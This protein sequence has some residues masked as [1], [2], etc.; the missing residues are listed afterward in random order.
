VSDPKSR[1]LIEVEKARYRYGTGD[2][3]LD[4][5]SF[6]VDSGVVLGLVGPNG[7]GKTTLYRLVLGLMRPQEGRVEVAGAAPAAH[8]R[9]FGIGYLPEQV[10]LPGNVRV[11][12]LAVLM[13]RLAG[14]SGLQLSGAIDRLMGTLAIE[15]TADALVGTLSHGYR[16]RVG[17]L[18]AL[19]G[20]PDLLLFDEPANGLDPA[21]IGVLRSVL[22]ALKRKGRTVIVS[23]HNL[24]ELE[25]V[26]DEVLI[27][28]Q[29]RLLGRTS[30]QELALHTDVWVVQLG[31]ESEAALSRAQGLYT[32]LEGVQLAADEVAFIDELAAR[33]F[34]ERVEAG[35]GGT[36][37]IERRP[38]D[39]EYLFHSL[40]QN[41]SREESG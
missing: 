13:A 40:V 16:Q 28:S 31:V 1:P 22:R 6:K 36:E 18:A 24:L 29:G 14:L 38:F 5:I 26:C 12:E 30:R 23:S 32:E 10:K 3:A 27:L 21:S 35:G 34:A 8:R 33:R 7:S 41:E 11:R 2:W 37:A 25:R 20:D 19:L 4:N 17:L 15:E 39:L 9:R